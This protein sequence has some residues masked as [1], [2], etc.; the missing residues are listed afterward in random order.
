MID[1]KLVQHY[2][3]LF[4]EYGDTP[5]GVQWTDL[6]TH[7]KRFAVISEIA[8]LTGCNVLDFGCGTGHFATYFKK[9]NINI[10]HY[11]GVDIVAEMLDCAKQKHPEYTFCNLQAA[12]KKSYD[13]TFIC[14][15][16]NNLMEDNQV[17]YRET[18]KEL[19]QVTK[20]G[21][22][23]NMMS[24]YVDYYDEDLFYEEP[25][26]VFKFLKE[27]VSPFVTL[28]S[29]YQI[30]ADVIPFEFTCYVYKKPIHGR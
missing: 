5:Q 13:F 29:D 3:Q 9:N 25:E 11:T 14:G 18:I 8:D 19:F 6:E 2:R 27:E 23:F 20:R 26:K 10:T 15:V 4:I 1:E 24:T 30:K 17:F 21:L 28:R 12:L 7:E 16:F 22:A